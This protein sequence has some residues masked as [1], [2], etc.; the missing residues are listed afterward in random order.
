MIGELL[1]SLQFKKEDRSLHCYYRPVRLTSVV[2]QVIESLIKDCLLKYL[3]D[4]KR[5]TQYVATWF[6]AQQILCY[7]FNEL[8]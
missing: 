2:C 5:V 6:P 4:I 8:P 1:M 7:E 3:L